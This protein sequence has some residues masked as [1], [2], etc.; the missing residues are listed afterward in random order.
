MRTASSSGASARANARVWAAGRFLKEYDTRQLRP[1]EVLLLVRYRDTLAGRV[2]ELGCGAGRLTGYLAAIAR[3]VHGL[4]LSPAMVDHCRQTLPEATFHEGD[5]TDLSMF[6][7]DSFDA[8]VAPC[9]VLDV[10]D[11]EGRR[12][13]LDGLHRLLTDDGLLIMSSH[14]RGYVP[15]LRTPTQVRWRD[16]LRLVYDIVRLPQRLGHRRRIVGL[17]RKEAGY[18]VLN[19]SAHN[20]SLLHYYISRDDQQRQFSEHGFNLLECL[21]LEG[22][23]VEE[24]AAVPEYVELHYVARRTDTAGRLSPHSD[25]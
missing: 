12:A 11:D 8:V 15:R 6:A 2:L 25:V 7:E 14:N 16:P 9:N 3:E 1:V 21:N 24:G 13:V 23:R 10:L 18:M 5:F 20:Y 17:E 19:D 4:D 22:A